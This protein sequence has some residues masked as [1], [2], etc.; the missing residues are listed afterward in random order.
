MPY[1]LCVPATEQPFTTPDGS[2]LVVHEP[3]VPM[4]FADFSA[5]PRCA[6]ISFT[7][8]NTLQPVW[9]MK[10]DAVEWMPSTQGWM[11]SLRIAAMPLAYEQARSVYSLMRAHHA[12]QTLDATQDRARRM[13]EHNLRLMRDAMRT[14]R[15]RTQVQQTIVVEP[16]PMPGTGKVTDPRQRRVT[17]R[18]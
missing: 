6:P 14:R 8:A 13:D 12:K 15:D 2:I 16:E 11:P 9:L 5:I 10:R 7:S 4:H 1:I 18:K 17:L 3:T